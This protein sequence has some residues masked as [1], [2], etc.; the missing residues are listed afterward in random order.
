M[1]KNYDNREMTDFLNSIELPDVQTPLYKKRLKKALLESGHFS[2]RSSAYLLK[3]VLF[4]S[5][6]FLRQKSAYSMAAIA[7]FLA[8]AI[9][10]FMPF[11]TPAFAHIV[12][13]VNPAMRLTIDSDNNVIDFEALD[14]SAVDMFDGMNFI[15]KSSDNAI[16]DIVGRLHERTVL[17]QDNQVLLLVYPAHGKNIDDLAN[18][19][20]KTES[21]INRRITELNAQARVKSFALKAEVYKAAEQAGLMP[22]QYSRLLEHGMT[23][24]ALTKLFHQ[25]DETGADKEY[26]AGHFDEIAEQVT[27]ALE[28]DVP[29]DEA[30]SVVKEVLA[31]RRGTGELRRAMRRIN[32]LVDEDLT[33]RAAAIRVRREIRARRNL[34]D[35]DEGDSHDKSQ[36]EPLPDD[37]ITGREDE[38]ISDSEDEYVPSGKDNI[39]EDEQKRPDVNDIRRNLRERQLERQQRRDERREHPN[40]KLEQEDIKE[41]QNEEQRRQDEESERRR[42]ERQ[43]RQNERQQR[44]DD[45]R[46][47]LNENR[48]N[49]NNNPV[50]RKEIR[51]QPNENEDQQDSEPVKP[52]VEDD[53]Q[54]KPDEGV[55]QGAANEESLNNDQN[56]RNARQQRQNERQQRRNDIRQRLNNRREGQNE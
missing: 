24:D 22:S 55:E 1:S 56:R 34:K 7:I 38:N 32:E 29:E 31:A 49:R 50:Q 54:I 36:N 12:L 10:S 44:R 51:E 27:K 35:I 8:F 11:S 17:E 47:R 41:Y 43:D 9:L 53:V 6:M 5:F 15:G 21:A 52:D 39:K 16:E 33:P 18:T 13:E 46:Q 20:N 2:R 28:S 26:F 48:Q 25:A 23:A 30:V 45:I 19:L 14:R 3:E 40:E 42:N 37:Q 4:S